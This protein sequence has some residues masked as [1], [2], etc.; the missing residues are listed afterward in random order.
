MKNIIL[1]LT[2]SI[3][4]FDCSDDSTGPSPNEKGHFSA[5]FNGDY[6]T[7]KYKFDL[8]NKYSH[9]ITISQKFTFGTVSN[10]EY[11]ELIPLELYKSYFSIKIGGEDL[12]SNNSIEFIL[13]SLKSAGIYEISEL[14]RII[15]NGKNYLN[16]EMKYGTVNITEIKIDTIHTY[17]PSINKWYVEIKNTSYVKGTFE[18]E[19]EKDGLALFISEG[20]FF[21]ENKGY[22]N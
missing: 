13:D 16:S 9:G 21:L 8:Y 5:K 6:W 4:L 15:Y 14:E 2:L 20:H 7:P 1:L 11:I 12:T 22:P 17:E 3:L 10:K 18:I 19:C